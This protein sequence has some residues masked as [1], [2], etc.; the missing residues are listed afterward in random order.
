MTTIYDIAATSGVSAM[1]VS[2]VLNKSKGSIPVSEKT[3]KK[4]VQVAKE[5]NYTTDLLAQALRKGQSGQVG[6]LIPST[7]FSYLPQVLEG[8]EEVLR[9]RQSS[10]LLCSTQENLNLEI[11][12]LNFLYAKKVDGLIMWTQSDEE[13]LREP[14]N[15]FL[16]DGK[17]VTFIYSGPSIPG[18]GSIKIDHFNGAYLATEYLIKKGHTRIGSRRINPCNEGLIPTLEG[19]KQAL[20]DNN[21]EVDETLL[22]KL[23]TY[24]DGIKAA[25]YFTSIQNPPT[26]V[27]TGGDYQA[28]G[29]IKQARKLGLKVPGDLA[30]M[31]YNDIEYAAMSDPGLTTVSV[32]KPEVGIT[33]AEYVYKNSDKEKKSNL[34]LPAKLVIRESA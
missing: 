2:R 27:F 9:K 13:K 19:Y 4:V 32:P 20:K 16:N 14:I 12:Y 3:R 10:L 6:V 31:G 17:T 21:I 24:H 8:I 18:T 22:A 1:T 29:V 33:A 25:D 5:M 34:I 30:V 15:R 26:A 23:D 7:T 11:E 28:L